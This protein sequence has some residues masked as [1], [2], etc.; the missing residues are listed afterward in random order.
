MWPA[1]LVHDDVRPIRR[2]EYEALAERGVFEEER[3]E[4]LRGVIV[5]MT[6]IGP[7]H[8]SAVERLTELLVRALVPRATVRI[9][10]SFAASDDSEPQPDVA[11]VPRASYRAAH[12]QTAWI[13]VE[14]ARSSLKRDRDLKAKLYAESKVEEYWIV[15]LVDEVVVV[16]SEIV[17]GTYGRVVTHRR[18]DV[19]RPARFPDVEVPVSDILG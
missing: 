9:Q 12:P 5:R 10:S 19:V 3:V 16:H 4:L 11:V 1:G 15:N 18:G 8:D 17:G 6:P 7:D 13:I 14:V 2:T